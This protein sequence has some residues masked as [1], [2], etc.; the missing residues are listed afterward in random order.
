MYSSAGHGIN[1]S[2]Y[3][4]NLSITLRMLTTV[5]NLWKPRV[6][7]ITKKQTNTYTLLVLGSVDV[8]LF[9]GWWRW[10]V[11]EIAHH[12]SSAIFQDSEFLSAQEQRFLA[13]LY[14]SERSF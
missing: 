1:I 12:F 8:C 9:S 2:G 7:E 6:M 14:I 10:F 5:S 4:L 11:W 3:A 13:W